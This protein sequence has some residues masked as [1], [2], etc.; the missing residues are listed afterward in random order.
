MLCLM[1]CR[2]AL[3]T[4]GSLG[5]CVVMGIWVFSWYGVPCLCQPCLYCDSSCLSWLEAAALLEAALPAV[6]C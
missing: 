2:D 6:T 1:P 4:T 5:W 3:V